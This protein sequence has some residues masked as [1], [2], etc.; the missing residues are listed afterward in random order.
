VRAEVYAL[1]AALIGGALAC[2]LAY[3]D[4]RDRRA[5]YAAGLLCGL[6]LANHHYVTILFLV[7][8]G[9]VALSRRPGIKAS[10]RVAGF[11]VLGLLAYAYLPLRALHDP[12]VEWGAP[13]TLARVWWT[14]SAQAFQKTVGQPPVFLDELAKTVEAMFAQLDVVGAVL[15]VLGAVG[16]AFTRAPRSL[17]LLV[18]VAVCGIV[19][20]A[21]LGFDDDNPDAFGYLL[22]AMAA[23]F[24]LAGAGVAW[25]C[26]RLPRTAGVA[27]AAVACALPVAQLVRNAD[28]S[29]LRGAYAAESYGRLVLDRLPPRT[30]LVTGYHETIFQVWNLIASEQARPDVAVIDRN[31]LNYDGAPDVARRRQPEL[32]AVIDAPLRGGQPTPIDVMRELARERPIAFELSFFIAARDPALPYL[33]PAGPIAWLRA[34]PPTPAER[35][36]AERAAPLDEARLASPAPVDRHGALRMI[37]LNMFLDAKFYCA[38]GRRDAARAAFAALERTVEP[39]GADDPWVRELAASCLR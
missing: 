38:L 25:L 9:A 16:L 22:P 34:D 36:A 13:D 33:V 39:P 35:D 4:T 7:P 14:I 15:A 18:G 12:M 21:V 30:L 5:L 28:D 6:G 31:M 24:V 1:E 27:A 10:L 8:A 29:S 37:R 2:V 26:G 32:R 3:D 20:R 11:G 23:A 19:G 17:I